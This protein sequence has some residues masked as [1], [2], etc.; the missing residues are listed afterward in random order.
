MFHRKNN[1][2]YTDLKFR[3]RQWDK[4]TAKKVYFWKGCPRNI[5]ATKKIFCIYRYLLSN[6][7]ITRQM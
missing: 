3:I 2:Y 4:W 1:L 7:V 5:S 6:T